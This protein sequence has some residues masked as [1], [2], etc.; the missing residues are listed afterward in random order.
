MNIIITEY[1]SFIQITE[2]ITELRYAT[3]LAINLLCSCDR[4]DI[5]SFDNVFSTLVKLLFI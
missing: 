4:Q 1:Q 2:R 5:Y 3:I